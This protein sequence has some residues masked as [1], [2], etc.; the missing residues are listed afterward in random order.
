MVVA[1]SKSEPLID[2]HLEIY[3][4]TEL[5]EIALLS[6]TLKREGKAYII[7]YACSL[8]RALCLELSRIME[9]G[10]FLR[11]LKRLI[12]RKGRP[13]KIYSDNA[14]TFVAAAIG[15]SKSSEMNIFTVTCRL[16]TSS[17]NLI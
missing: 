2:H 7:L 10:E 6:V 13:E 5:R 9:T 8:M 3:R 14:K 17:G 11:S 16:R 1:V 4:E 12:A 15:K